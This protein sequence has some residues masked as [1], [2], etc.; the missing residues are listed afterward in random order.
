MEPGGP[1]GGL[2]FPHKL[3]TAVGEG[4]RVLERSEHGEWMVLT[5]AEM[6]TAGEKAGGRVLLWS[7][8]I[9]G[10]LPDIC[11]DKSPSVVSGERYDQM[12][13]VNQWLL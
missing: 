2:L 8:L 4:S 11:L 1:G 12:S 3:N 10:H 5:V 7:L 9:W 13:S 6:E